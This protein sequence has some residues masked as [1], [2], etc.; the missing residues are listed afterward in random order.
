MVEGWSG[1]RVYRLGFAGFG[2]AGFMACGVSGL[3]V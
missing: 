2:L 1:S 3:V